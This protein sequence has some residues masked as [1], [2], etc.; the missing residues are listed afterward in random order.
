MIKRKS[1][2]EYWESN[3]KLAA[4]GLKE[5]NTFFWRQ[6]D[7]VF[8]RFFSKT[9]GPNLHL[10]EVGAGAS[11]W[12]PRLHSKYGFQVSGL[13][14][15]HEG[16]KRCIATFEENQIEGEV[17]Q[18]DMFDSNHQLEGRFDVVCS[19]G[20]VE[21]FDDT[22]KAISA[23]AKFVKS[24]GLVITF[25]PNMK[26][27]NGFF[28]KLF[29]RDVFDTHLP[30]DLNE[31]VT[32]HK[33]AGLKVIYQ[34]YILSLPAVLDGDRVESNLFKKI[35]RKTAFFLTKTIWWIQE[36]IWQIPE[37][38]ITSPY[39]ICIAKKQIKA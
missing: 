10:L 14:Y 34:S 20:L 8:L 25:I 26:G 9:S 38:P 11:E 23:C 3:W 13:D 17:Y 19:F 12:L 16:C 37:S 7:S 31:L 4:S 15:S 1:T 6:I 28:Y 35:I 39:M 18:C 22:A 21:H 24:H 29:N 30:I 32:A 2:K 27:I 5:K 36:N 33:N